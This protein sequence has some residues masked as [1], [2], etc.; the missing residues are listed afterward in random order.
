[1][2]AIK[3]AFRKFKNGKAYGYYGVAAEMVKEWVKLLTDVS[4][5]AWK[6]KQI[7]KGWEM[8]VIFPLYKKMLNSI[9]TNAGCQTNSLWT[10]V[11]TGT[12][13]TN[14]TNI[15]RASKWIQI[16]KMSARPCFYNKVSFRK[17]ASSKIFSIA[18][19]DMEEAFDKVQHEK[20]RCSLEKRKV[21][22][23]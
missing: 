4:N 1:M 17:S 6:N 9:I 7:S 23:D 21:E 19:I 18:F 8:G 22:K 3:E 14:W 2:E 10:N 15:G 20:I 12:E 16:R 5:D 13:K 11:R